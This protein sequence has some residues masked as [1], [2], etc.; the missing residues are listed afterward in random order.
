MRYDMSIVELALLPLSISNG[1][2]RSATG[3]RIYVTTLSIVYSSLRVY[4][5]SSRYS[6]LCSLPLNDRSIIND[7]STST[8][9]LG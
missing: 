5:Y 6:S 1:F 9:V 4:L 2:A 7:H 3:S 8:V